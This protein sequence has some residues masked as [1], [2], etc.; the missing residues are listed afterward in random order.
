M[1]LQKNIIKY[2]LCDCVFFQRK[3]HCDLHRCGKK[4][5]VKE[6]TSLPNE[7]V[8]EFN[9]ELQITN[10]LNKLIGELS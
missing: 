4:I 1:N 2:F 8:M 5:E 9:L 10:Y 6:N 3:K 7:Y